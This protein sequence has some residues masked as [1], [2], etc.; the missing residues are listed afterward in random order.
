VPFISDNTP[1]VITADIA[2]ARRRTPP[3][4]QV[5]DAGPPTGRA[6]VRAVDRHGRVV[7]RT[8]RV[9]R[10]TDGLVALTLPVPT[11][12]QPPYRLIVRA[13]DAAGNAS[14]PHTTI[15]ARPGQP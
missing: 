3:V 15:L 2:L 9:L 11:D 1:P 14:L 12:G 13:F 6:T 7:L 10:F 5:R 8:T 4:V